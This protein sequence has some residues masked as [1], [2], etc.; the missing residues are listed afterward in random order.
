MP[1]RKRKATD[2]A[3]TSCGYPY[4]SGTA[5][6]GTAAGSSTN[7]LVIDSPPKP[8][9]Q[10]KAKDPDAPAPEKRGAIFKKKCPQNIIERVE[11]VMQQRCVPCSSLQRASYNSNARLLNA[12]FY[13]I[14]R[15]REGNELREE[16]SVLGSTGNVSCGAIPSHLTPVA[17]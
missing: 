2:D 8:K 17:D 12:R 10:R 13:M 5:S 11:R 7:P 9:R 1:P 16:F 3:Y 4:P 15:K 14:D 6:Y